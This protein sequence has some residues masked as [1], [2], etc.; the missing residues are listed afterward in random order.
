[1]PWIDYGAR[2]HMSTRL[3]D[4]ADSN[5][6]N[7]LR[8]GTTIDGD[9]YMAGAIHRLFKWQAGVTVAYNGVQGMAQMAT[10][11]PLDLIARFEPMPEFNVWMGRMIHVADRFMTSG[12]WGADEYNVPGVYPGIAAPVLPK[13]GAVGRDVGFNI[14][15]ALFGGHFKYY[16]GAYQLHDPAINPLLTGRLQVSLLSP[17][18]GFY[19]RTTYYGTRDLVSVGIGGQ[20]QA[21]GS[22]LAGMPDPMMP[23]VTP[24]PAAIGDHTYFNFDVDVEKVFEP[25]TLSF[26]GSFQMFGGDGQYWDNGF[27]LGLGW[28]FPQVI[29][30]GK[31]RPNVRFQMA[32]PKNDGLD[33]ATMIEVQLSYLVTA[34]FARVNL[35]YRRANTPTGPMGAGVGSNMIWLGV[36]LADP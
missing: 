9:I 5:R 35:G 22:V 20:Y 28:L 26:V 24:A 23:G 16:A 15:G 17:E 2:L 32:N 34:W 27:H 29:G 31:F 21:N 6:P 1:M 10:V 18:P 14:W 12:P 33:A 11:Q 7:S 13:T 4:H 25:G 3:T 36:V 8:P 19:Q 30:V